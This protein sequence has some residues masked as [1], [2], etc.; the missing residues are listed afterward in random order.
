MHTVN[1]GAQVGRGPILAP[2]SP[3]KDAVGACRPRGNLIDP[4]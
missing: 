2:S 3:C 1:W 4:P